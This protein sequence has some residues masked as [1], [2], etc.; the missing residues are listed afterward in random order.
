MVVIG[1][2]AAEMVEVQAVYS[3]HPVGVSQK[4]VYVSVCTFAV[5][6]VFVHMGRHGNYLR[7]E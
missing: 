1:G 3:Q 5:K 6:P 4:P 7:T 2:Y